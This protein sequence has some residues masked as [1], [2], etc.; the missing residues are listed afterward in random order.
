MKK[1]NNNSQLSETI[2]K[3]L[4]WIFLI[5]F[6]SLIIPFYWNP[7]YL[8]LL[9]SLIYLFGDFMTLVIL[10]MIILHLVLCLYWR[11]YFKK[12]FLVFV[13]FFLIFQLFYLQKLTA[14]DYDYHSFSDV[15]SFSLTQWSYKFEHDSTLT[16]LFNINSFGLFNSTFYVFTIGL[17][18]PLISFIITLILLI[19]IFLIL[20]IFVGIFFYR[21][22]NILYYRIGDIKVT[23][24]GTYDNTDLENIENNDDYERKKYDEKN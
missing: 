8:L 20:L 11:S 2:I 4:L 3:V 6:I 16:I 15:I 18:N 21:K 14:S 13:L 19:I 1:R 23:F 10:I 22:S 7:A 17:L 12:I 24:L 9:F 5:F